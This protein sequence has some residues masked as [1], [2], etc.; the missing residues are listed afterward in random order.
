MTKPIA[1]GFSPNTQKDDVLLALRLLFSP[2]RYIKGTASGQLERWFIKYF[3]V[4]HAVSFNSGRSALYAILH[5]SD[6]GKGDEVIIQAFTCVAVPNAIIATGAMP[7]YVDI[8]STLTIDPGDL[9]T[10]ITKKT[11]AI[12]VQHTF[13]IPTNMDVILS[14]AQK[15]KIPII[16][17]VA[18]T[19]GGE[20]KRKKLGTI[21]DA[22]IFSF[23]REKAFSSVFGGMAITN[24]LVLGKKLHMYQKQKNFPS[25][26]WVM[27]QLFYPI[28]ASLM[29][30]LYYVL[31]IGKIM[32]Y[33]LRRFHFFSYPV[34]TNEKKGIFLPREVK[35]LPN[36]LAFLVL[37]QLKKLETYNQKRRHFSKFYKEQLTET[38]FQFDIHTPLLRFPLIVSDKKK[39]KA[40][41]AKR[42][43][44][45][46]DFYN[47]VVD[48][49]G[50]HLEKI[51]YKKGMCPN[52][53]KIAE[54]V[55]NLP[56][57]PTMTMKDAQRI[58]TLFKQYYRKQ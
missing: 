24:D 2:W 10:K 14:I 17:D 45:I 21:G 57:Y 47:Q 20:Y 40:Y 56:T 7:I 32:H 26:F 30:T 43:I 27:Q 19:I 46:G 48:P 28:I 5:C 31:F 16:E 23:G 12:I 51:Y 49:L 25:F 4:S 6:I 9:E 44:Y 36:A 39:I 13:G 52:A 22:A 42:G 50:V 38:G 37:L 53:E 3:K 29:L 35:R 15:Y 34:S 41:F 54:Q 33:V 1:I 8:D 18:H 11:K 55:I 58:I